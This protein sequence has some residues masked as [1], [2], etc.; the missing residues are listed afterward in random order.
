MSHVLPIGRHSSE[1][2]TQRGG[3][4][5][6][7]PSLKKPD[8]SDEITSH[9]AYLR[10]LTGDGFEESYNTC[11]TIR[12]SRFLDSC[13]TLL[14]SLANVPGRL[15]SSIPWQDLAAEHTPFTSHNSRL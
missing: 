5:A 7:P 2:P 6:R 11:K 1:R 3:Q 9:L 14:Y 10:R 15:K 13:V 8:I 12:V 4:L